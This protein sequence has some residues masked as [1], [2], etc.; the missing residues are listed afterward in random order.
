[1]KNTQI[2]L[3][4]KSYGFKDRLYL[5][6]LW[7]PKKL[8]WWLTCVILPFICLSLSYTLWLQHNYHQTISWLNKSMCSVRRPINAWTSTSRNYFWQ[9]QRDMTRVFPTQTPPEGMTWIIQVKSRP[10]YSSLLALPHCAIWWKKCLSL[11]A[12]L[13]SQVIQV[14]MVVVFCDFL[15]K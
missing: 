5:S 14:T 11:V 10:A 12:I 2:T 13:K 7:C 1:M 4:G 3:I 15:S 9:P 6:L 8:G